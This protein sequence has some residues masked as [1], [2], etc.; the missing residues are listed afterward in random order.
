MR[1]LVLTLTCA[2]I[3][4]EQGTVATA[5]VAQ[6]LTDR[7]FGP[8]GSS[9]RAV[10]VVS[11]GVRVPAVLTLP[12]AAGTYP[13]V[14]MAHGHGG[15][16]D[17]NG[18]F[19]AIADALASRG[20]ASIR[21][22]FPGCGASAEPFTQNTITNMMVDVA[23]ARAY[24]VGNAPI[25]ARAVGIFGYSMGGRLAI[26]SAASGYKSLGLLAPKGNDGADPD[27]RQQGACLCCLPWRL[28]REG[29]ADGAWGFSLAA[30]V[31]THDGEAALQEG[32]AAVWL[33][34]SG[35]SRSAKALLRKSRF[36]A[37]R[38]IRTLRERFL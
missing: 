1:A 29:S 11:R 4:I 26:L 31:K 10:T 37:G 30:C 32:S 3:V 23:A 35:G 34:P 13:L 7:S 19:A 18:G 38:G 25:D 21:M 9:A 15:S 22:D 8:F 5:L 14:V 28:M 6:S 20:I 24:A 33:A 2:L 16:K 27:Q 17:E 12:S 36:G